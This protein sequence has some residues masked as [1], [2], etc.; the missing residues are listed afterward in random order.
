MLTKQNPKQGGA[1]GGEGHEVTDLL[2]HLMVPAEGGMVEAAYMG[3]SV[4]G[5]E[6]RGFLCNTLTSLG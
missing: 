1:E 3:A 2:L 6:P 4:K 5:S